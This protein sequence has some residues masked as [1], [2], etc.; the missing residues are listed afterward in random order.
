MIILALTTATLGCSQGDPLSGYRAQNNHPQTPI[1]TTRR[2]NGDIRKLLAGLRAKKYTINRT[3]NEGR[4]YYYFT[5]QEGFVDILAGSDFD[6][7]TYYAPNT[8]NSSSSLSIHLDTSDPE[9]LTLLK[10]VENMISNYEAEESRLE[11]LGKRNTI[12][13][14]GFWNQR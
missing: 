12:V 5:N 2:E 10:E 14:E 9:E 8:S 11:L 1:D 6:Y 7:I 13:P 4:H 3:R